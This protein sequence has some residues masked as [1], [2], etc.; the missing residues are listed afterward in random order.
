MFLEQYESDTPKLR[1]W[2]SVRYYSGLVL[3]FWS[4]ASVGSCASV[5][6]DLLKPGAFS[7]TGSSSLNVARICRCRN[8]LQGTRASWGSVVP[9][10]TPKVPLS[11]FR[12]HVAFYVY[13]QWNRVFHLSKNQKPNQAKQAV[14]ADGKTD[15]I[16]SSDSIWF[17]QK[18]L[19]TG[20]ARHQTTDNVFA[21]FAGTN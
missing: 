19:V 1:C 13:R 15:E 2:N 20:P 8:W 3:F 17:K 21:I 11:L 14:N 9:P 6:A 10:S 16:S 12:V 7:Y 4:C 18:Q 5:A